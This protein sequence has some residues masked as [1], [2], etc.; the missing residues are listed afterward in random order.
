MNTK[1]IAL[2]SLFLICGVVIVAISL[3][4]W[5]NAKRGR[6]PFIKPVQI[7]GDEYRAPNTYS[8]EGVVEAWD[9]KAN[10]LLWRTKIYFTL[11]VPLLIEEDAQWNFIKSMTLGPATNELTIVNEKG[12]QYILNTASQKVRRK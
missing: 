10:K 6:P 1:H 3:V 2:L 9:P 7:A 11:H 12:R 4:R 5:N 8:T